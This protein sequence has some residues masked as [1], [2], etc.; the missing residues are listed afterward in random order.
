MCIR[1]RGRPPR[2]PDDTRPVRSSECRRVIARLRDR[3]VSPARGLGGGPQQRGALMPV[4]SCC[5]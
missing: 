5:A 4:R 1:D 2:E 3:R